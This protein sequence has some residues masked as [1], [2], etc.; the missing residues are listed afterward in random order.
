[1]RRD[2]ALWLI[3]TYK[4]VKGVL[5]LVFAA[6]IAVA[7]RVG[8][9]DR[10]LGFAAQLRHHSRAWSLDLAQLLVRAASRR[11]L[12]TIIVALIADG[13]VSLIEGWA[14]VHGHWWGPWLVV[15]ATGSFLPLEV[16]ALARH[17]NATRAVLLV[18]NLAIVIYLAHKA[19]HDRRVREAQSQAV[20]IRR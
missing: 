16:V 6:V 19:V 12:W 10:L 5:W 14:L 1:M 17:V 15:I 13:T 11:G 20:E 3:I 18:G 4:L 2:R 8:L 9:E 7:M